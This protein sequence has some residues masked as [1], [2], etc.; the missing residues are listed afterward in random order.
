MRTDS[1]RHVLAA[2][3]FLLGE[4][5]APGVQLG[6]NARRSRRGGSF[7]PDA[8]WR[9]SS[10]LS[11]YFTA[12]PDIPS[13]QAV[14]TWRR[15]IWNEGFAPLL[16]VISPQRVDLYNGFGTPTGNDDARLHLLRTFSQVES[17][18]Q[19]L[20]E[21][22]GRLA[23]ETGQFWLQNAVVDR[24]TGVDQKL[25]SDLAH[26]EQDLVGNDLSRNAAQAL[27]GRVIFTQYLIDRRIVDSTRLKRVCGH[28]N[29]PDALRERAA[30]TR[31]FSWLSDTFNGDMFPPISATVPK[32]DYLV[33]VADF[34]EAVDPETSQRSFFPYQ[35]DVI[36]VEL[37]SSIYEQFVH[38][39]ADTKTRASDAVRNGVH[40][41]RLSLVSLVLDEVMDGL[42]GN[43]TV[44]DL[45]C[46]SGVFLVEALRRLVALRARGE[47]PTR[48]AI[49]LTLYRQVFGV[50][51][52][53]AAIRVAAFSLYLGALELDPDPQPPQALRFQPLIG[54]TLHIG[55]ARTFR[56]PDEKL[57]QTAD[58]IPK[59]FDLVVG[60]PPWSFKGKSGTAVRRRTM[61]RGVPAQPRGEGLDFVIRATDFAHDNT[62]FGIVL[63]ALP[64]FSRSGTGQAAANHVLRRLAPV[65]LVNL[66][67]LSTW[68]FATASM[69]AVVLFARHRPQDPSTVTVVQ[70]PWSAAGARTHTFDVSTS[71][72]VRLPL[73]AIEADATKLKA[74]AVGRNRDITLLDSITNKYKKLGDW[75]QYQETEL[76]VGLIRGLPRNQTRDARSLKGL[77]LLETG[78]IAR[79]TI[80]EDLPRFTLSKA[81][82]PRARNIYRAPL[83]IVK[84]T[85]S[86][87]PRA[88]VAVS[89]RDLVF[90]NAFFGASV[91]HAHETS[92]KLLAGILSSSFA[93][94]YFVMTASE[95]GLW[96]RRL[97]RHDVAS[98]PIPDL[99]PTTKT[100]AGKRVL[101]AV[102]ALSGS[103]ED[104]DWSHLDEA[105]SD[106]YGLDAADRVVVADG[107]F[108][109]SWQWQEGREHSV[110]PAD[111][112]LHVVRYAEI[113]LSVV[114]SWLAARN[115]RHMRAEVFD[116]R[117]TSALRVVRFILEEGPGDS[118]VKVVNSTDRISD[119][120]DTL[121]RRLHVKLSHVLTGN[122]ELRV[123]GPNEVVIIKPSARRH[124]LGVAALEDADT[125]VAESFTGASI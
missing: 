123:H 43:E 16:W 94:W 83:I 72:V 36:P 97:L 107:L 33:R 68:L 18:L 112:H 5:P 115:V 12:Q 62:R 41:T 3:G 54:K 28:D 92:L 17:A 90:T 75:L 125:V 98:L 74:A 110:A 2:T 52:S 100:V 119:V 39:G 23:L 81:Q 59:D 87:G 20:D 9:S 122:R 93:S 63:S 8:V 35:F 102:D 118:T 51:I 14:S 69:P 47:P 53:E 113:F 105:V 58:A 1:L 40:Y 50:D 95:F 34:L 26:L 21:F 56:Q 120:L 114:N 13:D 104:Y 32:T 67:N 82:W 77:E 37:I 117:S 19:E 84:E 65:T 4:E 78:D 121:G 11:V 42:T 55:D 73:E 38:A 29:L 79:F 57:P 44:L 86:S 64:F 46:G 89:D 85:L 22:A 88:I 101:R 103:S 31:L 48:E 24:K 111:T 70:I 27:I 106:I 71:N 25:L 124:W 80:P 10:S 45:T 108:R 99:L 66:S 109:G 15:E 91:S 76:H 116:L 49:R 61:A 6:D 60:N 7:V 30:T 96:K